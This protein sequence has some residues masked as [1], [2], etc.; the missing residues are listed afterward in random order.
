[1]KWHLRQGYCLR[2]EGG[3]APCMMGRKHIICREAKRV[4]RGCKEKGNKGG[5]GGML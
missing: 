1:M 2:V 3:E 5:G 4:V